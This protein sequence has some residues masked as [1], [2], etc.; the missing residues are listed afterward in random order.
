MCT[1]SATELEDYTSD[2]DPQASA[3]TFTVIEQSPAGVTWSYEIQL[4]VYDGGRLGTFDAEGDWHP[5]IE[6]EYD[7]LPDN[8][9]ELVAI[10]ET[11]LW[12]GSQS[13]ILRVPVADL[14]VSGLSIQDGIG[15][16]G[17]LTFHDDYRFHPSTTVDDFD[18]ADG[19]VWW[20]EDRTVYSMAVDDFGGTPTEVF[21]VDAHFDAGPAPLLAASTDRLWITTQETN[22]TLRAYQ[23]DG[24]PIETIQ[25]ESA[26]TVIPQDMT[27]ERNSGAL[28]IAGRTGS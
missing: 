16:V 7:A 24:D 3:A 5:M 26:S 6:I 14:E 9:F 23:F 20:I 25:L 19:Q 22:P 1:C 15:I 2:D 18:I 17:L 12:L 13:G 27:V 28:A 21:D 11:H 8:L 10:D 4:G